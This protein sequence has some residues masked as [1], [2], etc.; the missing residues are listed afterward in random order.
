MKDLIPL[1]DS[2]FGSR[3][4]KYRLC[5]PAAS[6]LFENRIATGDPR[7]ESA[8]TNALLDKDVT[9]HDDVG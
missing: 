8:H 4:S 6:G 5:K 9:E 2:L 3:L 7:N 1:K